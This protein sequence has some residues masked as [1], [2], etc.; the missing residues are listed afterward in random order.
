MLT[1]LGPYA[2]TG[3]ETCGVARRDHSTARELTHKSVRFA[4]LHWCADGRVFA[5]L[6]L[7]HGYRCGEHDEHH[8][9]DPQE[10][11]RSEK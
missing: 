3:V 4:A 2:A 9:G 8:S 7:D 6:A 10:L 11:L 5:V 1:A